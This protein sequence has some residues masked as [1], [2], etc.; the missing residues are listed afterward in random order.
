MFQYSCSIR[1]LDIIQFQGV[2]FQ[3]GNETNMPLM[4]K[5]RHFWVKMSNFNYFY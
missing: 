5:I 4:Q 3:Q 1:L 2:H